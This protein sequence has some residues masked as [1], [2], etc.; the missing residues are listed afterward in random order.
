[1]SDEMIGE[2]L[3]SYTQ[4]PDK[5][6][7]AVEGVSSEDLDLDR[8]AGTWSIRQIV[9]HLADSEGFWATWFRM[10]VG[11]PGSTFKLDW[12]PGNDRWAE[13]LQYERRPIEPALALFRANR[14]AVA[15][16]LTAASDCWDR[17]VGFEFKGLEQP[18]RPNV[19]QM[20]GLLVHHLEEHVRQIETIKR[21]HG[22]VPA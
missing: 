16:L 17:E 19:A 14:T 4:G 1:M 10:A 15:Q 12:Y 6:E 2:E 18:M 11:A 8:G 7:A 13:L 3:A 9:H 5:L 22:G 21:M 20:I